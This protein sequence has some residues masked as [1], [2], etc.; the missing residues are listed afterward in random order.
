MGET[1]EY[2]NILVERLGSVSRL[3]INRPEKRNALDRETWEEIRSAFTG[4]REDA[5]LRAVIVTGAGGKAF[6]SGADIRE[7]LTRS[8]L[9][10]FKSPA[11]EVLSFVE[12]LEKPVIAAID[13]FCLGGGCELAMACD[14]RLAT[15]RSRFGLPEV[16]LG[17]LP[18]AGGTQRLSRLVGLGK[19]KELILTGDIISAA[20]AREIGLVNRV[21]ENPEDLPG[22]AQALAEKIASRGPVAVALAKLAADAGPDTDLRTGLVLEKLALALTFATKDH[23]EGLSAFLEKRSPEYKG[24]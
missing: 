6:A 13:G 12:R 15:A 22:Q 7:L 11:Q 8:P 17:I 1:M 19:A 18:G 9:A 2:R 21:V 24:E 4:F 14:I 5:A 16:T 3:T 23:T 20:E 10:C